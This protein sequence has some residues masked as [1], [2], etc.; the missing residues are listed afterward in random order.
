MGI[1]EG[2]VAEKAK[3]MIEGHVLHAK[4]RSVCKEVVGVDHDKAA[5]NELRRLGFDEIIY[6][7]AEHL[8]QVGLNKIFDIVLCGDLI[9][10]LSNPGLMLEGAK[11]FMDAQSEFIISAP[12][13]FGGL[14]FLRYC[15]GAFREG[16][17]HVL[18]FS[19]FTLNNLL[20]RHRFVISET[21]S[22]YNRP[23]ANRLDS[24]RYRVGVPFFKAFPKLGGTLLVIAKLQ[25]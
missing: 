13:S 12:N 10:H 5:V 16:N 22:C 24:L 1:T 23:P 17:D 8:E 25:A 14:H 4:L 3:A 6:G 19:V 9:E 7:N 21:Y 18:S 11:L 2:T 20:R 15:F